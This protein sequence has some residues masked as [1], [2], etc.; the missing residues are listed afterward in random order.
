MI[1]D[2]NEKKKADI[3]ISVA[4]LSAGVAVSTTAEDYTIIFNKADKALYHVKQNGKSGYYFYSSDADADGKVDAEKIVSS[5]R[6][7]GSYEG[8]LDVEYRQF[9]RLY[10]YISNL[11]HR[12]AHPF[13]LILVELE[14][15]DEKA[16]QTEEMERAMYF[17]EQSIRQTIRSVDV[18]TRYSRRQYLIILVGTD[19]EGVKIVIDRVFRGYYKMS[20]SGIFSPRYVMI[21][22]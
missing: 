16:P 3:D 19:N 11:E 2:L 1:S 4:S 12:F 6:T 13:K 9:A 7:S 20:G 10:E 14:A 21:L 5:I 17:M 22:G 8:A 18:V 15:P